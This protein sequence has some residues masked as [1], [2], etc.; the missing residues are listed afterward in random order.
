MHPGN[1]ERRHEYAGVDL[2]RLERRHGAPSPDL[3]QLRS[4]RDAL[5]HALVREESNFNRKAKSWAGAQGLSQLMP[6]T[7]R[8]VA[9]RLGMAYSPAQVYDPET[10]LKIGARYLESLFKRHA[11]VK[12]V[13]PAGEELGPHAANVRQLGIFKHSR[14]PLA[15][16]RRCFPGGD[17]YW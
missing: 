8:G 1:V 6:A 10:N 2:A 15:V 14:Q 13:P 5:R 16:E 3:H 9:G 11:G 17:G 7:A 4:R 12:D